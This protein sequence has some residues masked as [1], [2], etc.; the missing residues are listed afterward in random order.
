MPIAKVSNLHKAVRKAKE[1]GFTIAGAVVEEGK[2]LEDIEL[3]FPLGLVIGSED[4]GISKYLLEQVD[5]PLTIPMK[6]HTMSFNVAHATTILC[7]EIKRQITERYGK[8]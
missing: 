8:K 3:P 2:K 7:N 4:K 5:L 6:I 1:Q